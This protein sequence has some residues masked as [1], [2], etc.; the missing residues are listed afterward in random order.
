[1]NTKIRRSFFNKKILIALSI[2]FLV[3]IIAFM[4]FLNAIDRFRKLRITIDNQSDY[5][6]TQIQ[7]GLDTGE[8]LLADPAS[9]DHKEEMGLLYTFNKDIASGQK[10][11]FT[12]QLNLRGEGSV[13]ITF[14]DSGGKTYKET[15]C[16]YTESLSGTSHITITNEKVT[17]KENCM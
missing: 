11:K 6:I 12:P 3:A 4:S 13:Y 1:M 5:D 9:A 16:G 2:L 15:A 14:Q 10:A 17:I 8:S 7:A